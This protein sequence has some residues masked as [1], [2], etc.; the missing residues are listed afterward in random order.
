MTATTIGVAVL[1]V[2]ICAAIGTM[3]GTICDQTRHHR[4]A[5]TVTITATATLTVTSIVTVALW[6]Q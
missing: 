1:I 5:L 6:W 4:W 3:L 2:L